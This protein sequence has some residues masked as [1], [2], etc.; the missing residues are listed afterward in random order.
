MSYVTDI[1]LLASAG[2]PGCR[3]IN[4]YMPDGCLFD[5]VSIDDSRLPLHW[6]GG[7]KVFAP[8]VYIGAI[9]NLGSI[10]KFIRHLRA[11][12]WELPE[13]VQIVVK[14]PNDIVFRLIYVFP[15]LTPKG[16]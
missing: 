4:S 7:T 8:E 1:I 10:D 6:C 12:E 3:W 15:E 2:E 13:C 14:E 5:L 9:N 16:F 11:I